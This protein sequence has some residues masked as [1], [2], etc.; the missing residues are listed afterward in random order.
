MQQFLTDPVQFPCQFCKDLLEIGME[1]DYHY[2]ALPPP[3]SKLT[4]LVQELKKL[5]QYRAWAPNHEIKE[6]TLKKE[7]PKQEAIKCE[8][9]EK[10]VVFTLFK[11]TL[12]LCEALLRNAGITH[13]R[14]DG[15]MK[16]ADRSK[17]IATFMHDESVHVLLASSRSAG[18]GLNL[19][20]ATTV[21]F[22]DRWS[23]A[24][25]RANSFVSAVALCVV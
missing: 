17:A 5:S 3:S 21:I 2:A 15:D 18:L 10:A 12:D 23:V 1:M 11:A 24:S 6:E 9:V 16:V 4:V 19:C 22:L 25:A 13:V 8:T 20:R 7:A 14:I